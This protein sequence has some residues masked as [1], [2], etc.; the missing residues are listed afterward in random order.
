MDR[1]IGGF[2]ELE[3]NQG[4][5]PYPGAKSFNSARFAFQAVLAHE[6]VRRVFLPFYTCGTMYEAA[7]KAE[8]E[9]VRYYLDDELQLLE[10]PEL[11]PGDRLQYVNYF[12]YKNDYIRRTLVP[13]YGNRLIVDNAQAL[14]SAPEDGITTLYSPRKFVGVP[15]G[16]WLFNAPADL[17]PPEPGETQ[18]RLRALLGRLEGSP[19]PFYSTFIEVEHS[20]RDEGLRGMS[21]QTTRLLRSL[22]Y[23]SIAARR[24]LNLDRVHRELGSLNRFQLPTQ[25][26]QAPMC[27]PLLLDDVDTANEVRGHLLKQR[28]YLA[29]YWRELLEQPGLCPVARR[30]TECML[31]LPI[32]QRYG[33]TDM[34][35][36]VTAVKQ[37][38]Q[39]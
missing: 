36:M 3:L 27:Y 11:Q 37:I 29:T 30:W 20:I 26:V 34:T 15:D 6:P 12:G 24:A 32:D 39:A 21:A 22:D 31:P 25:A 18:G 14:F 19:E 7:L 8:V 35:R 2:F 38:L 16:G 10:P 5:V 4:S 23:P 33:G 9:V 1:A 13:L 17:L 28:I